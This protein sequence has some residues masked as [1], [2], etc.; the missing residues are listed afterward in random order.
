MSSQYHTNADRGGRRRHG[1]WVDPDPGCFVLLEILAKANGA[2]V[3]NKE[4]IAKI[5]PGRHASDER[6]QAYVSA[7]RAALGPE[8]ARLREVAGTGY[9]LDHRV[10]RSPPAL[11]HRIEGGMPPPMP[12]LIGREE[13]LAELKALLARRRLIT[14]T[15]T[16]GIGK[17]SV[18]R[19]LARDVRS[20]LQLDSHFVDLGSLVD[21]TFVASAAAR[22]MDLRLGLGEMSEAA[23]VRKIGAARVL[24]VLD[25]CEHLLGA[26]S[27]FAGRLLNG[28]RNIRILATSREPLH[29]EGEHVYRLSSLSVPSRDEVDEE[30]IN[31]SAAAR[32]FVSRMGS[33]KRG[34]DQEH[35]SAVAIATI[36]RCLDGIPL[37]LEFAAAQASNIGIAQV[38][39][40]LDARLKFLD[41]GAARPS[42]Q[43][44]LRAT[45]DWSYDLLSE[46]ERALLRRLAVFPGGFTIDAAAAVLD[47]RAAA[48]IVVV[49]RIAS[50][51][52]KS[53]ITHDQ[54]PGRW[55]MLETIRAYCMEKLNERDEATKAA[56]RQAV[57]LR[58]QFVASSRSGIARASPRIRRSFVAELDNVRAALEWCFSEDGNSALGV[59]LT[60]VYAPVWRHLFLMSECRDWCTRAIDRWRPEYDPEERMLMALSISNGKAM[61]WMLS[62]CSN[63]QLACKIG[64]R[65]AE[66]LEDSA[67]ET[68]ALYTLWSTHF[69]SGN[70]RA[71]LDAGERLLRNGFKLSDDGD[72][73]H[74][75]RLL[76]SSKQ[77]H[78]EYHEAVVLLEGALEHAQRQ[79]VGNEIRSVFD[80][81]VM[82]RALL[83]NALW[84]QGLL[85]R[86]LV[87]VRRAAE[88]AK[89]ETCGV[90]LCNALRQSVCRTQI[91]T[92][93]FDC[94][95]R[96]VDQL[97]ELSHRNG[98]HQFS[99]TGLCLEG[100]LLIKCGEAARGVQ[101]LRAGIDR[102]AESGWT[103]WFT[104]LLAILAEGL[105]A[106]QQIPE[107]GV[108]VEDGIRR[109]EQGGEFWYLPEL[110]RLR[111]ELA[112]LD[113]NRL[114]YPAAEEWFQESLRLA[115]A[116]HALFW[117]IR[118]ATSFARLR[119]RQGLRSEARRLLE[120][121]YNRFTE[122]FGVPD[123]ANARELTRAL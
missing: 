5:D 10:D 108:A 113:D 69:L 6:L 46:D 66:R 65:I 30:K 78:G 13:C 41:V 40:N 105:V 117:E 58:D 21:E 112:V 80:E 122:G 75:A 57:F 77:F 79:Q 87:E 62:P 74:A 64:L 91:M 104:E 33:A 1:A 49:E 81:S 3:P 95:R 12:A 94:A 44:T 85:D 47:E 37:A 16:G 48:P 2:V 118:T 82:A 67:A 73:A 98:Y 34:S 31:A 4:L 56:R 55:R 107:A 51:A 97:M 18:A 28:C 26:V 96:S 83:G 76:G 43:Q 84:P 29:I 116:Q 111:G 60:A 52:S 42:R 63:T 109:A 54:V 32:L 61:G 119:Q 20:S 115:K 27:A 36:C 99:L 103:S 90:T 35:R 93:R 106:L 38:A 9:C 72:I 89:T 8:S 114:D 53:L 7:A 11:G 23:V 102:S 110:L 88:A 121:V 68:E 22:S 100:A 15:G 120:P 86:A 14:I 92:G 39:A 19:A 25:N 17:T 45:L 101:V 71:S 70:I 59:S 24:L 123:V 50:L